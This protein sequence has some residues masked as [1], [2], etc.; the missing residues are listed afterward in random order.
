MKREN[1]RPSTATDRRRV[2]I[3][4]VFYEAM[5][6]RDAGGQTAAAIAKLEEAL[7]GW[8]ELQEN[9][10]AEMTAHQLKLQKGYQAFSEGVKLYNTKTRPNPGGCRS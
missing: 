10:L 3:E 4:R 5:T 1:S 6:A 8:R 2:E 7:R 9:E